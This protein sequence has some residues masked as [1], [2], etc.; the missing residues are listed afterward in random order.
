MLI[1]GRIGDVVGNKEGLSVRKVIGASVG[2]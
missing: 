2:I 1:D